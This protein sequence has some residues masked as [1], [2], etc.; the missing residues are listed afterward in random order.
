MKVTIR[1]KPLANG[2]Q[3]IYLDI[4]DKG[5][6]RYEYPQLYIIPEVDETSKRM[7]D[8]AM[9]KAE[10]IKQL[11]ILGKFKHEEKHT[12]S[13]S[14]ME[15]YD[16]YTHHMKNERSVSKAVIDA[17]HLIRPI[18]V[19]YL[20]KSRKMNIGLAEFG[21]N[22]VRGFLMA[23]RNWKAEKRERLSD[24]TMVIYQQRLIAMFNA[25]IKEGH[26]EKNPFSMIQDFERIPKV[27]P[28]KESLCKDEIERIMAVTPV[29]EEDAQ[30]K[31]A[32]LFACFTGMR[33][34]DIRD[35]RWSD[36]KVVD[37]QKTIVKRQVKT[38]QLVTI[39]LCQTA[40]RFLPEQTDDENIFHLPLK[41]GCR[42]GLI[43]IIEAAS[44]K[45]SVTFHTSRHTFATLTYASGTD[46]LTVSKL[47]GH[48]SVSTTEIYADVMMEA[49]VEAIANISR[50]FS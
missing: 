9:R 24:G 34:S 50:V 12:K 32:F 30:V 23:M 15:W 14:L 48:S 45:K 3:S 36:I 43:R 41:T 38:D 21:A 2:S 20:T 49:K 37:G 26:L 31:R 46:L 33:I 39:P 10:E 27:I 6:R 4:Y 1:T 17:L 28:T 5:K 25:A 19:G 16:Q 13:L 11:I 8:N 7:N 47:L 42:L 40:L 29:K 35:L 44:I 22:E 18:L